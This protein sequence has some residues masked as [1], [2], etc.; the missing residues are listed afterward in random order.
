MTESMRGRLVVAAPSLL[1]PNF[2]HTVVYL[3]DHSDEGA[4]GIVLNRPSDVE[5]ADALPRWE[6]LASRPRLMYVGGPVQPEAIVGLG[7]PRGGPVEAVEAV[8]EGVA[9]VDLRA[10]PLA[11]I[12]DLD[13]F[14]L[15]V[16]Y[17]GWGHGQLE[18]EIAE[19]GWFV[20][21]ARAEDVFSSDTDDL[22]ARVLSRQGGLFSTISENPSLN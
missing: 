19:G 5:V 3:I 20:V 16:G 7:R 4:L 11:L 13:G 6:P 14:R 1:D 2:E 10:D 21:D 18:A 9:V 8:S 22:W 12:G 17:A 15:F